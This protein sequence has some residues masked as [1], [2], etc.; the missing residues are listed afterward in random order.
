MQAGPLSLARSSSQG[1]K[2]AFYPFVQ[3][4]TYLSEMATPNQVRRATKQKEFGIP[5]KDPQ[6]FEFHILV[7][8]FDEGSATLGLIR[9]T[10]QVADLLR[11]RLHR[12]H[13]ALL[14]E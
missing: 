12:Q 7:A 9:P 2:N 8:D 5:L 14:G 4:L 3:L 1:T 6:P 10:G 13:Q 11:T